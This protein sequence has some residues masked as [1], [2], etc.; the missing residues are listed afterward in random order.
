MRIKSAAMS[1]DHQQR[2]IH[3]FHNARRQKH[4]LHTILWM[5]W[6]F[7]KLF[8]NNPIVQIIVHNVML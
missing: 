7:K 3:M 4:M 5:S 2:R 6:D 8:F 1:G